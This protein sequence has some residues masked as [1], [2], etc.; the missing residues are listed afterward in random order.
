M[1]PRPASIFN[2]IRSHCL[3]KFV[4]L[5]LC[6]CAEAARRA[7]GASVVALLTFQ[8]WVSTLLLIVSCSFLS[9]SAVPA[10]PVQFYSFILCSSAAS[11][12]HSA[13]AP[14]DNV[15]ADGALTAKSVS[16]SSLILQQSCSDA[17][18]LGGVSVGLAHAV[19]EKSRPNLSLAQTFI[20]HGNKTW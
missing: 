2:W 3:E 8:T 15:R 5:P 7:G 9:A 6:N 17:N 19:G 12:S 4:L 18:T 11:S 10:R 13:T 20:L 16:R 1:A 14:L